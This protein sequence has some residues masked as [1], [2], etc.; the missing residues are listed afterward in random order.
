M[1]ASTLIFFLIRFWNT[2]VIFINI[3]LEKQYGYININEKNIFCEYIY[4]RVVSAGEGKAL[5]FTKAFHR[6]P[7]TQKGK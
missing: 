4:C 6:M 3:S 1:E 7:F 5:Y 2:E